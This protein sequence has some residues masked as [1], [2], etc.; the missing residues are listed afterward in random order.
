MDSQ[1]IICSLHFGRLPYQRAACYVH[2]GLLHCLCGAI[3]ELLSGAKN[4]CWRQLRSEYLL[5]YRLQ[6]HNNPKRRKYSLKGTGQQSFKEQL[7]DQRKASKRM[8]DVQLNIPTYVWDHQVGGSSPSTRT[9]RVFISFVM[10]TR[11]NFGSNLFFG[12]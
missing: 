8:Q 12:A 11:F 1:G 7:P 5:I 9:K 2:L 6:S 4:R 10:D 3:F